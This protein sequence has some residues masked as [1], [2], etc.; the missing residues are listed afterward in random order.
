[1]SRSSLIRAAGI[2]GEWLSRAYWA[3]AGTTDLVTFWWV[4]VAIGLDGVPSCPLGG[5]LVMT[6]LFAGGKSMFVSYLLR[7]WMT[8]HWLSC[9]VA[10]PRHYD[11]SSFKANLLGALHSVTF[12]FLLATTTSECEGV[13][14]PSKIAGHLAMWGS[15]A[16][17]ISM[18]LVRIARAF[19]RK[20]EL[21]QV[22]TE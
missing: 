17:I 11:L 16:S 1:M 13:A 22:R 4:V 10:R 12:I 14:A 5:L 9:C 18:V 20:R 19:C 3:A 21:L 7:R 2:D 15:L 8:L 6:L